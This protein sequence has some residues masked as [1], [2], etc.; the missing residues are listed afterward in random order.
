[1]RGWWVLGLGMGACG[2]DFV[3]G[4][5][6]DDVDLQPAELA[7]SPEAVV[8]GGRKRDELVSAPFEIR[9]AGGSVLTI[10]SVRLEG[11]QDFT[12]TLDEQLPVDLVADDVVTGT[13][14]FM[15]QLAGD[16][17][18]SLWVHPDTLGLDPV[19]VPL[20][21]LGEVG[22]VEI[23]P[24][25][26][27]YGDVPIGCVMSRDLVIRNVGRDV[28]QVASIDVP[29]DE[30]DLFVGGASD[31][32]YALAVGAQTPV[33]VSK[34]FGELGPWS[35]AI[36]VRHD[37]PSGPQAIQLQA[38]VVPRPPV[39]E[40]FAIPSAMPIDLLYVVD[41][42]CSMF[43]QI[44]LVVSETEAF[45]SAFAALRV[46]GRIAVL[47]GTEPSCFTDV[48]T[49]GDPDWLTRLSAAMVSMPTV[50]TTVDGWSWLTEAPIESVARASRYDVAAGCN[51]GF[52][53]ESAP[54]HI[55]TFSDEADQSSSYLTGGPDYWRP[56]YDE[57]V[58]WAH[59]GRLWWHAV[60]DEAGACGDEPTGAGGH[61]DVVTASG[62]VMLNVCEGAWVDDMLRLTTTI[63][64]SGRQFPLSF[65]DVVVSS[66]EVRMN[67]V[68]APT[69]WTFLPQPATVELEV[70]PPAGTTVEISYVR[71]TDCPA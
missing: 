17:A 19:E 44:G 13:V 71:V 66:V 29:E 62:G 24:N 57:V 33:R 30:D 20:R 49:P 32:D 18:G 51:A 2:A 7:V 65:N 63:T 37:A 43:E 60:V 28:V 45:T 11:A 5:R 25:P 56:W 68:L 31:T 38:M 9:N 27:D 39:V 4:G 50:G 16:R 54:L 67:G 1:M 42:S 10:A 69:G 22:A 55:L 41:Q 14:S 52:R 61:L 12:L 26:V 64:R 58:T 35:L 34:I 6:T 36:P 48:I 59:P 40:R 15:P 8:F 70:L 46:D 3:V 47:T 23:S 21:G 53:R